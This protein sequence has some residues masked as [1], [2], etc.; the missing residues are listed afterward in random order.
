[1]RI[2]TVRPEEYARAGRVV[3]AAYEALEG[4]EAVAGYAD[5]LADVARRARETEVL[6]AVEGDVMGCVTLVPDA[7]SPWAELA[8]AD[9]AVIRM[10]GVDP[11]AQGGGIGTALVEACIERAARL[12][13]SAVFLFS[14]ERMNVAHRIYEK[15]GFVRVPER[16]WTVTANF[17]LLAFRLD[18]TT[19]R[20]S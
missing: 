6:V 19:K 17:T 10:L 14:T 13:R 5:E 4:P 1:V 12:G 7:S 11:S 18:L 9:E 15:F 3:L 2:R 8:K 20:N 16:D